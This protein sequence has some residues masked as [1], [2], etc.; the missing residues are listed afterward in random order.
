M[1]QSFDHIGNRYQVEVFDREYL[2][3]ADETFLAT[4][5][6]PRGEGPFS[7]LLGV[8][9]GAWNR[10]SRSEL[11][12]IGK[13]LAATGILVATVDFRLAPAH[14]YPAQVQDVHYACRWLKLHAAEFNGD[15]TRV[16]VIGTSSGG[17]TS[18]LCAMRPNDPRY[19]VLP[20]EAPAS[21]DATFKYVISCWG[22]IDPWVR[23]TFCQTTPQAGE[24]FGGA[25]VKLRQTLN[26]FLNEAAMHEGN[27]QEMLER[28]EQQ[29]LPPLLIIQGTDDMNIP[30]TLPQRF[31]PAYRSAGGSAQ[32]E[33]FAGESHGFGSRPGP[34][35]MRAID[36]IMDFVAAQLIAMESPMNQHASTHRRS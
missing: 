9:G 20:L 11:E 12:L 5:Y 3:H 33:W 4:I 22:V 25:D 16:G 32:I 13:E 34:A 19:S 2:R 7:M 17:H 23:Y 14:P 30:L 28:G 36:T 31:A 29:E 15:A 18:L 8:H 1:P 35:A 21:I 6:Q 10:G 27:P 26:Y 24:G